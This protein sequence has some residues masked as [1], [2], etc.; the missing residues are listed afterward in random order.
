[1]K[2]FEDAIDKA[3][4][5]GKAAIAER[6][7][8]W[9]RHERPEQWVLAAGPV[10][11]VVHLY[12]TSP[13]VIDR[14]VILRTFVGIAGGG[15]IEGP[16]VWTRTIVEAERIGDRLFGIDRGRGDAAGDAVG[17]MTGGPV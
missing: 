2:L 5:A 4:E 14:G 15:R 6:V 17:D 1:M 7:P 16:S 12:S 10:L 9:T 8:V 3:L 13:P 11:L